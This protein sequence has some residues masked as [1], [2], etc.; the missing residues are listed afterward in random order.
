M[1]RRQPIYR[2]RVFAGDCELLVAVINET[3]AKYAR[4][5]GKI[6]AT[7]PALD[8]HLPKTRRAK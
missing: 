1:D 3:A 2:Y 5:H 6:G 8:G 7:K 4:I